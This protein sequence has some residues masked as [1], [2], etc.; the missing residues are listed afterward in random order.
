MKGITKLLLIPTLLATIALTSCPM[1]STVDP[2]EVQNIYD[3]IEIIHPPLPDPIVWEHFEWVVL[4]PEILRE[5]LNKYDNGELTEKQLVFFAIT[6]E[7]YERLAL[8]MADI[9]RFMK[10]Q[11]SVIMYYRDRK[12]RDIIKPENTPN[13]TIDTTSETE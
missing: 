1:K 7:G 5:M 6:P 11:K 4:T 12:V 2:I 10:D 13:D 8:N 3:E 9:R